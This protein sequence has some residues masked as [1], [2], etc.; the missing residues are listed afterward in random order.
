MPASTSY[1]AERARNQKRDQS[2]RLA[3]DLAAATHRPA[4]NKVSAHDRMRERLADVNKVRRALDMERQIHRR[5]KAGD[6]Y[7]PHDLSSEEQ[8]KWQKRRPR[9]S[10][11]FDQLGINPLHEYKVCFY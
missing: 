5:W 2:L 9:E 3:K 10:D 6:V 8:Q 7:A 11:A 1:Y 4:S